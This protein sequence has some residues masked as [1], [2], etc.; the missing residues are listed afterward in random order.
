MQ[1]KM[2]QEYTDCY[3]QLGFNHQAS[4]EE[5]RQAYRQAM[6]RWHPD[7]HT[8]SANRREVE[9]K[10]KEIAQAYRRL[11]QY[12]R[13]YGRL[14]PFLAPDKAVARV[15][16]DAS[17]ARQC[18]PPCEAATIHAK[19]SSR[20]HS[21]TVASGYRFRQFGFALGTIVVLGLFIFGRPSPSPPS[22]FT[23]EISLP[24]SKLSPADRS[25]S[26]QLF[27]IGSSPR[28]VYAAQGIPDRMEKDVWHYGKARVYFVNSKVDRWETTPDQPL[29]VTLDHAQ[30]AAA[31]RSTSFFTLGSTKDDVRAV[32][33]APTRE[34]D[35]VW[36]YGNSRVYFDET[37]RV[38]G[39]EAS[40]GFALRAKR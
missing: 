14:P 23:E 26:G 40:P 19:W 28:E 1:A 38:R 29:R 2:G 34:Q 37:G 10:T 18:D 32:Q 3:R 15:A 25:G 5:I 4:W 33:D 31:R 7:R 36:E 22:S 24:E 21:A 6:R 11:A 13:H 35:R 17:V 27:T 39:W 30:E 16:H 12:Y 9:E 20:A 8:A